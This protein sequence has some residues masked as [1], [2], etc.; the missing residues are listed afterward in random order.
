MMDSLLSGAGL[1]GARPER[2][3]YGIA[4][5]QVVTNL[6]TTG[7][8]RVQVRLPWLPG[9][10]PWA[11]VAVLGAGSQLGTY[12]MPQDG[13]EVLVAFHQGEVT[14]AYVIGCV[15]NGRDRSPA[16]QSSDAVNRRLIRTPAGHEIALDEAQRSITITSADKQR[17]SLTPNTISVAISGDKT[18]VTLENSG[19]VTIEASQRLVLRA[20]TIQ[21]DSTNLEMGGRSSARIDG[22]QACFIQAG[23]VFIN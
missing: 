5:A 19:A 18:R 22:G 12:F 17:V 16:T 20:P 23:K 1:D 9:I 2:R 7:Q 13:D 8:G 21:L 10:Q 11:R 15:W 6:D 14:D 3:L 4:L